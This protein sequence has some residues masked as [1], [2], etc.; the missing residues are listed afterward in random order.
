M[1]YRDHDVRRVSGQVQ[2]C[3]STAGIWHHWV[4]LVGYVSVLM[5]Y[6]P[7]SSS[8]SSSSSSL[9]SSWWSFRSMTD[10]WVLHVDPT[11]T[12][13]SHVP[14]GSHLVSINTLPVMASMYTVDRSW[15]WMTS[16]LNTS[17]LPST[18]TLVFKPWGSRSM[19]HHLVGWTGHDPTWVLHGL[20]FAHF[21][22]PVYLVLSTL[23]FAIQTAVTLILINILPLPYLDGAQ[24][25]QSFLMFWKS[26]KRK[27][28]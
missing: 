16:R 14:L 2:W 11:S 27:A 24:I 4:S 23:S 25:L 7:S 17:G 5:M 12:L 10:P 3:I 21:P 28:E 18:L 13:V 6:V 9:S 8:S 20:T 22:I 19:K 15:P 26:R 1:H